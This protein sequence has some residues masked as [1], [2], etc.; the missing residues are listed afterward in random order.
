MDMIKTAIFSLLLIMSA[1]A[2]A[3][4][5]PP[6]R[7]YEVL[8]REVRMPSVDNGTIT[9]RE[10][11]KCNYETHQVT[12]RTTYALNGKNMSLEDFRELVEALRL[13]GKHVVNV[14]RDLDT[15]TIT[16]V[17]IYTQ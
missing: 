5:Y 13:E 3:D 15:D 4:N 9:V 2:F 8:V 10:C 7:T 11:A 17:F 12:P 6:T 14:R 1:A 16:K